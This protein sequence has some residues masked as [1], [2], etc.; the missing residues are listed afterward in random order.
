LANIFVPFFRYFFQQGSHLLLRDC[1]IGF[2]SLSKE[3][4]PSLA[5]VR[6][7]TIAASRI[8]RVATPTGAA[9]PPPPPSNQQAGLVASTPPPSSIPVFPNPDQAPAAGGPHGRTSIS[10]TS[11][12]TSLL[13]RLESAP[14]LPS[15]AIPRPRPPTPRDPI[16]RNPN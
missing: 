5:R 2:L 12:S 8:V 10:S 16:P 9:A 11:G 15:A 7:S 13:H 4:I 6:G 3:K 14:L 1:S